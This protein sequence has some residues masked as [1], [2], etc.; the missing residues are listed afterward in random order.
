MATP[1]PIPLLPPTPWWDHAVIGALIAGAVAVLLAIG[2]TILA[3]WLHRDRAKVDRDLARDRFEFDKAAA[4]HKAGLDRALDHWRRR[5]DFAEQELAAFYEARSRFTFIRTPETFIGEVEGRPERE[6]EPQTL[7][8]FR[9]LYY[10]VLHRA[11]EAA[12]FF[13]A[14]YAR[15]F[16]ASALLGAGAEEPYRT[17]RQ[18]LMRVRSASHSLLRLGPEPRTERDRERYDERR[19]RFE[20]VVWEDWSDEDE[21]QVAASID[22]ALAGAEAIFQPVIQPP[23]G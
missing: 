3:A 11:N 14:F 1:L 19:G 13:D 16:R 18:A 6:D 9:D 4:E 21:D 5:V 17:V 20:R 12:P 23:P 8:R 15:R 7:Q 10:P 2:N 22:E